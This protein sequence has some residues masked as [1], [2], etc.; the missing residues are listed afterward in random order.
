MELKQSLTIIIPAYN[1]E[2][3][4]G[5]LLQDIAGQKHAQG[6]KVYIADASSTD[7]TV[8]I[9]N[10]YSIANGGPL[11]IEVI[12]GGTVTVGRNAGLKLAQTEYVIFIDA[13]VRLS[14]EMQLFD[15]WYRLGSKKLVGS[16]LKSISGFPSNLVYLLFNLFN[17]CLS[18]VRPFAV[19]AYFATHRRYI[20]K[21]GWW[22]TEI[23]HGEDWVLSGRYPARD[24]TFCKYPILVDDRRFQR[25]GYWGMLKLMLTSWFKG[26]AYMKKDQ[27]YWK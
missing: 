21:F 1:E 2:K 23:I 15:T 5:G 16:R 12:P 22:N 19:G 25:T 13:D 4:I 26:E 20:K 9:C 17:A 10:S 6:V 14:N 27:G 11:D 7:M 8:E 3:Y 24:F 18:A